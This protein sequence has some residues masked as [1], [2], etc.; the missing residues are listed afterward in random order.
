MKIEPSDTP[1]GVAPVPNST[2]TPPALSVVSNNAQPTYNDDAAKVSVAQQSA[3]VPTTT[4]PE[5]LK[6]LKS[7]IENGTYNPDRIAVAKKFALEV[8]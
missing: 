8:L 1:P 7:Q 2:T 3:S 5:R 6:E 4:S